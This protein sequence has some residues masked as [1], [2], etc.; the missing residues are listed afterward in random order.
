MDSRSLASR[1]DSALVHDHLAVHIFVIHHVAVPVKLV[2]MALGTES[3]ED[4]QG[5]EIVDMVVD[6]PD[7]EGARLLFLILYM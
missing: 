2:G 3:D 5:A 6:G 4:G 7:A 1:L